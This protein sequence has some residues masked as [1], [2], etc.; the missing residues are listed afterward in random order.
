[1]I[2]PKRCEV[3]V[4]LLEG[5]EPAVAK[6]SFH[7]GGARFSYFRLKSSDGSM[8]LEP[9]KINTGY[10]WV[11][12][13]YDEDKDRFKELE[14]LAIRVYRNQAG[15]SSPISIP[16]SGRVKRSHSKEGYGFASDSEDA[17]L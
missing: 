13:Y 8:W 3:R 1:M 6:V 4:K 15:I 12:A 17:G 11:A 9:P 2:D 16:A 10:K 7:Q 14:A 5:K